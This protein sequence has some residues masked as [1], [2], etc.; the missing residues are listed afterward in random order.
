[1]KLAAMRAGLQGR[2]DPARDKADEM[3]GIVDVQRRGE[4]PME[5]IEAVEQPVRMKKGGDVS[6]NKK[7]MDQKIAAAMKKDKIEDKKMMKKDCNKY[8]AG[9]V[10]KIRLGQSDAQGRQKAPKL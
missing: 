8:A 6:K 5:F 7:M 1:M 10:A 3:L 9:G 4:R 2:R